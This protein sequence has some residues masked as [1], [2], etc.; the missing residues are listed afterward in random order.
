MEEESVVT[1]ARTGTPSTPTTTTTPVGS[2]LMK[3]RSEEPS[4]G[5][6]TTTPRRVEE[7]TVAEFKTPQAPG[8]KKKRIVLEEDQYA[9][10]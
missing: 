6:V 8:P 4:L 3:R 9:V 1:P 5:L 10:V 2:L 7:L